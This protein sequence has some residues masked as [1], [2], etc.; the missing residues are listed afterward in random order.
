MYSIRFILTVF[1][2]TGLMVCAQF[3][4]GCASAPREKSDDGITIGEGRVEDSPEEDPEESRA[5]NGKRRVMVDESIPIPGDETPEEAEA[6]RRLQAEVEKIYKESQE[7]AAKWAAEDQ[8]WVKEKLARA[9]AVEAEGKL[10]E[11]EKILEEII[12]KIPEHDEAARRL[13]ELS[14]KRKKN[15]GVEKDLEERVLEL[16]RHAKKRRDKKSFR[17]AYKLYLEARKLLDSAQDKA[18]KILLMPEIEQNLKE[19]ENLVPPEDRRKD[20]G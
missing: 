19:L 1:A 20:E 13:I 17:A 2:L 4:A 8:K 12:K 7:V 18:V 16:I 5:E 14:A 9:K 3:A 15:K 11:A 6:K 10:K